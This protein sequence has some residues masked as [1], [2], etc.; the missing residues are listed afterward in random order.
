[1]KRLF[2]TL[3]LLPL[4]LG[5]QTPAADTLTTRFVVAGIPVILRRATSS[6]VVTADVYLL[7]GARQ[8]TPETA[9][10]EPFLLD[11]SE[12][13]TKHFPQAVLR[14]VMARLGTS[15]VIDPRSDWT[16]FGVRATQETVDSTFVV[17]ADRLMYPRL[18]TADVEL[19]RQQYASAVRQRRDSPDALVEYLADS[20]SYGTHPYGRQVS[21]TDQSISAITVRQLRQ[22]E[23]TQMVRSRML[24][25]VVGNVDRP[26]VERLITRTL[27]RL[28]LG[29]YH[30]TL[31]APV[32]PRPAAVVTDNR[33]LP[34]NYLLGYYQGPPATSPDYQAL[35]VAAAVLS[36]R[37][38]G[39]VRDQR[40]L[41]YAVNAPFVDRAL[42]QGGLYVTTVAPDTVLTIMRREV[43]NLQ[44]AL[45][46]PAGLNRLV[47]QFITEYFLDN[48]TNADQANFL[49]R[50]ELYRGDYR[51]GEGDRFVAELR[52]VSPEDVRRVAQKY[53][54]AISFAYVG[55]TTKLSLPLASGF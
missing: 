31:P 25:V 42:A 10:I 50:A 18:D 16:A 11:V 12:R 5:G 21:G 34:T 54:H 55:D 27:A 26:H 45:V 51:T 40:N 17:M 37:L 8:V 1:M 36:G 32:P 33:Q 2:L 30:W 53:M 4:G 3:T 48:E 52:R 43:G 24:I 14:H 15:I 6:T 47:Q 44:H 49:A 13:G 35:R 19:I 29:I 20:I 23:A 46:D 38:F 41:S 28:P 22:Y 7:G 9:G 39:E